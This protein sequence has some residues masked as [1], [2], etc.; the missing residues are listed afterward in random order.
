VWV[1]VYAPQGLD[2][3]NFAAEVKEACIM[4]RPSRSRVQPPRIT[5]VGTQIN[6]QGSPCRSPDRSLPIVAQVRNAAYD[7][8]NI[9]RSMV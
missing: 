6:R 8:G 1:S 7:S 5:Q 9:E 3:P 4:D 2:W